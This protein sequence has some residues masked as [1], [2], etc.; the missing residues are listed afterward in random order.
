RL[1]ARI[2]QA[3]GN[4]RVQQILVRED[5]DRETLAV[6]ETHRDELPGGSV[7]AVPVRTYPYGEVA[8]H[9]IGFLNQVSAADLREHTAEDYRVGDTIGRSGIERAWES[10]LRGRRGWVRVDRDYRGVVLSSRDEIAR[11]G[12][13]RR[14]EPVPGRDLVLTLDMELMRAI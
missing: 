4:R 5:I 11:F 13:D 2:R 14:L 12:P 9:A 10:L 3:E 7:I 6:I 1:E 8:A